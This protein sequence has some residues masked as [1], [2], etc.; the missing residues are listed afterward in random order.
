MSLKFEIMI[1]R[2]FSQLAELQ[3]WVNQLEQTTEH[4]AICHL[5][6]S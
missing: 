5:T 6:L 4:Y 1:E 2:Y 3:Y